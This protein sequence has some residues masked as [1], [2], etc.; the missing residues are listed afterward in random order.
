MSAKVAAI[1]LVA[2]DQSIASEGGLFQSGRALFLFIYGDALREP[3]Q[4]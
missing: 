2:A 1:H 3:W 4:R